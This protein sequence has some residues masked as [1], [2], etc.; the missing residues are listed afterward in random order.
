MFLHHVMLTQFLSLAQFL[1]S[2]TVRSF[3]FLAWKLKRTCNIIDSVVNPIKYFHDDSLYL[4]LKE[5]TA[6]SR[7]FEERI[8][9]TSNHNYEM[10]FVMFC[11]LA[12]HRTKFFL[13][14]QNGIPDLMIP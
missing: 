5:G 11:I 12:C 4:F 2:S 13:G 14:Q 10:Y 7:I 8:R 1:C 3:G 6:A 9:F